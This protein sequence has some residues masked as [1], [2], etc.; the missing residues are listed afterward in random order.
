MARKKEK[1]GLKNWT[2]K[3]LGTFLMGL[4][5]KGNKFVGEG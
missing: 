5:R 3:G 1:F 4:H 2:P